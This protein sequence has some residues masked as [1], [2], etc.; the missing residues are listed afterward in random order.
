MHFSKLIVAFVSMTLV[1]AVAVPNANPDPNPSATYRLKREV[2]EAMS[3]LMEKRQS[4]GCY[5]GDYVCC[6][7]WC[8]TCEGCC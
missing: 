2:I 1:A 5:D 6:T 3:D 7:D 4:C 8:S